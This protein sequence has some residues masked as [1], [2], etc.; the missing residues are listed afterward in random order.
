MDSIV[1][2]AKEMFMYIQEQEC[3][4]VNNLTLPEDYQ[5]KAMIAFAD[6]FMSLAIKKS[7]QNWWAG[8]KEMTMSELVKIENLIK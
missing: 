6:Q 4:N 2:T 5:I 8:K 1:K 3:P 7:D